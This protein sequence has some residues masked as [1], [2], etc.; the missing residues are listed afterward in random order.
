MP[1][2]SA[3]PNEYLVMRNLQTALQAI[4]LAG[5][6]YYDVAAVAVKLDPDSKPEDLVPPTGALPFIL[7]DVQQDAYTD[8]SS[9][10][11]RVKIDVPVN[12]FWINESEATV[13]ES[14][15]QT[16]YRGCADVEKAIVADIQRGGLAYE[17]RIA[18]RTFARKGSQVWAVVEAHIWV[19]RRYGHPLGD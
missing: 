14:L 11:T 15:L 6:Y 17:T 13:D 1:A 12:I 8:F 5:G 19:G 10:P 16:F 4:S 18:G 7:I 9:R 3:D 2:P